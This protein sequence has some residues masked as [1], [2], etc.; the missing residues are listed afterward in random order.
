M[1]VF[2]I[3]KI[4]WKYFQL[5]LKINFWTKKKV[6]IL[7]GWKVY[8]NFLPSVPL[9]LIKKF[10]TVKSNVYVKKLL[11]SW[12]FVWQV[13]CLFWLLQRYNLIVIIKSSV[14]TFTLNTEGVLTYHLNLT[15]KKATCT[16]QIAFKSKICC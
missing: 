15:T 5:L 3:F 14:E 10:S 4:K 8:K 7:R 2:L 6:W 12:C 13:T 9:T 16:E 11:P 1:G